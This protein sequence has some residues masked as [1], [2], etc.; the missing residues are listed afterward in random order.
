MSQT[1]I[2]SE[3]DTVDFI[4][5]R[6]YGTLEARVVERLLDANKGLADTPELA[7]G[8]RVSLPELDTRPDQSGTKL[9]D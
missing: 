1:Y 7:A 8:T 6:F 9:W 3:G 2:A 5:W 4:A